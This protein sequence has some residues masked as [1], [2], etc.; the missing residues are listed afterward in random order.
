[1]FLVRPVHFSPCPS[2]SV[3]P[4]HS[5]VTPAV[6]ESDVWL[7]APGQSVASMQ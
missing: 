2:H 3:P 4:P 1:M 7:S 5:A 6:A